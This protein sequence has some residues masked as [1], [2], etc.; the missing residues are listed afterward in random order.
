MG[1]N[2]IPIIP[3][4]GRWD[5]WLIDIRRTLHP[6]DNNKYFQGFVM[7]SPSFE[8]FGWAEECKFTA[9][10][11]NVYDKLMEVLNGPCPPNSV[12]KLTIGE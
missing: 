7:T 6:D 5:G 8:Q 4:S 11:D 1:V 12:D 3:V 2:V 9:P 10:Y